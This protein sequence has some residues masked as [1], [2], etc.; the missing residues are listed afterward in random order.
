MYILQSHNEKKESKQLLLRTCCYFN[1]YVYEYLSNILSNHNSQTY[2]NSKS[3]C[4]IKLLFNI[5]SVDFILCIFKAYLYCTY[6]QFERYN[7]DNCN[8][9]VLLNKRENC[10][11]HKGIYS[12]KGTYVR[13]KKK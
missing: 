1:I 4:C 7:A 8:F 13:I 5:P 12:S 3:I 6:S 10:F 9:L 11:L 2:V